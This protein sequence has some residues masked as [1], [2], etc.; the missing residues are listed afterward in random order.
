MAYWRLRIREYQLKNR[1]FWLE[2]VFGDIE[3]ESCLHLKNI[4]DFGVVCRW[5]NE[6][7]LGLQ[8][9]LSSSPDDAH[10]L[11]LFN[12]LDEYTFDLE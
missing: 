5:I 11:W 1:D 8:G 4:V 3:F 6:T 10:G 9:T 2:L 12:L 7:G